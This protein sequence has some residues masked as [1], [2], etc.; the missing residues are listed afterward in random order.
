[1]CSLFSCLTATDRNSA[2]IFRHDSPVVLGGSSTVRFLGG[3]SKTPDHS[4]CERGRRGA[5][6]DIDTSTPTIVFEVAYTQTSQSLAIESARHICL[7]MGQVLL[8]VAIDIVH[9]PRGRTEPRVL[10]SVTWS[11]WEEDISAH[12]K[13][14]S[15]GAELNVVHAER[16]S[17]EDDAI[18]CLPP[19]TAFSAKVRAEGEKKTYNI[20]ATQTESWEVWCILSAAA[21][22]LTVP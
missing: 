5:T 15:R 20:R 18:H 9:E 14:K 17:G 13:V 2:E 22:R 10:R 8:V 6:A 21:Y 19:A 1:M 7:T 11:H 12:R 3:Q 4:I 16:L